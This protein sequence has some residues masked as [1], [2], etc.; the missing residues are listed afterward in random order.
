MMFDEKA[1]SWGWSIIHLLYVFCHKKNCVMDRQTNGQTKL[2]EQILQRVVLMSDD[3]LGSQSL[4]IIHSL[5][6]PTHRPMDR[7]TLFQ[8]RMDASKKFLPTSFMIAACLLLTRGILFASVFR[9][10]LV[11]LQVCVGVFPSRGLWNT[12]TNS[13]LSAIMDQQTN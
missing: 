1:G 8:R 10:V 4:S 9:C 13:L 5:C 7:Q 12:C 6:Q 3:N 11:C 2:L